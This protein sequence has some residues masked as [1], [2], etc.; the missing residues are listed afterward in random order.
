MEYD[1]WFRL[2]NGE[3]VPAAVWRA[4]VQAENL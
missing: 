4:G 2:E 3:F 1:V